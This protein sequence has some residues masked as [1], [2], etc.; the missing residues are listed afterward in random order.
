MRAQVS[1]EHMM[2][3]PSIEATLS[4]K[5]HGETPYPIARHLDRLPVLGALARAWVRATHAAAPQ[6]LWASLP[7]VSA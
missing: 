5:A 3:A 2:N 1:C 7:P 4:R 6:T